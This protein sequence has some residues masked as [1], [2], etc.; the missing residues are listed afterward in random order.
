[1]IA[2]THFIG[3]DE[4]EISENFVRASG[5]GGQHVNTTASAVQ[6]RFDALGSCN[7]PQDLKDR[8]RRLAGQRMTAEGVIIITA[9]SFRSQARNRQDALERLVALLR[10]ASV[11]PVVRRP[12]RPTLAS[13]KRRLEAK[14]RRASTKAQRRDPTD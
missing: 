11:R 1:M 7:L 13:K 12:T 3:I 10:D 8:L 4:R 2:I 14:G 6:L 5:P 9:E